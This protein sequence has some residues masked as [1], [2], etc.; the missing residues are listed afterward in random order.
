MCCT[1]SPYA[2]IRYPM[3][4]VC[5]IWGVSRATLYRHQAVANAANDTHLPRGVARKARAV[6]PNCWKASGP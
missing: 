5:R 2:H 1:T 4:T 3:A 6:M